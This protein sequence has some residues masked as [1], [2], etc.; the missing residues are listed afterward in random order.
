M[1]SDLAK[2]DTTKYCEFHRDHGHRTNDCIQLRKEINVTP[3]IRGGVP[4]TTRQPVEF[5]WISGYPIPRGC[6]PFIGIHIS[7]KHRTESPL[8]DKLYPITVIHKS[9]FQHSYIEHILKLACSNI[10]YPTPPQYVPLPR[11]IHSYLNQKYEN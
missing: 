10:V 11:P 6:V 1:K 9:L 4:L 7:T 5:L 3:Q 8:F 2:R